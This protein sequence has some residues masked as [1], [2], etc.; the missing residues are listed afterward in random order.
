MIHTAVGA[1]FRS[2]HISNATVGA[3]CMW[4][5]SIYK[6]ILRLFQKKIFRRMMLG[7]LLGVA[8]ISLYKIVRH[9]S[10]DCTRRI[11]FESVN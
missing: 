7:I 8:S 5:Y 11:H 10:N 1:E 2:Q 9:Y 6:A 3:I 4:A